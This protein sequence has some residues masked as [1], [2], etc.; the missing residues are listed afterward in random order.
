[1]KRVFISGALNSF[2]GSKGFIENVHKMVKLA[3]EVRDLGAA[4]YVP[5]NDILTSISCGGLCHEDYYDHDLTWLEVCEAMILVPGYE[6]SK[7]VAGEMKKA[8]ELEI[9][10]FKNLEEL[11]EFINEDN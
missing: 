7:G 11:A 5:C 4:T 10:I 6:N 9:P 2:E 1:M 3:G 8:K